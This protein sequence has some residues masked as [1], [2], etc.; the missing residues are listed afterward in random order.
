MVKES[1]R[2]KIFCPSVQIFLALYIRGCSCKPFWWSACFSKYSKN[3]NR[4][5]LSALTSTA[6]DLDPNVLNVFQ[7][8][9]GKRLLFQNCKE[10]IFKFY[11]YSKPL[12]TQCFLSQVWVA[13]AQWCPSGIRLLCSV[14]S[15]LLFTKGVLDFG[16][17]LYWVVWHTSILFLL[18]F[19]LL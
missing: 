5:H 2:K 19:I 15:L 17:R 1:W 4:E 8:R 18:F 10:N 14:C 9:T 13:A 12:Q 11:T 3:V 7:M 6:S 16:D